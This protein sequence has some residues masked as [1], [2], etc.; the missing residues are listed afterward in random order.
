VSADSPPNSKQC[1]IPGGAREVPREARAYRPTNHFVNRFRERVP[2]DLEP[3]I[4]ERC[5]RYGTISARGQAGQADGNVWQVFGFEHT[6]EGDRWRVIVGIV[7]QAYDSEM[8]K[9]EAITIYRVADE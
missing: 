6:I 1:P 3:D 2:D 9:H 5:L 4:V 8:V 7:P